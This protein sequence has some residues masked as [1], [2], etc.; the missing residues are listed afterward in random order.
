MASDDGPDLRRVQTKEDFG[1]ELKTLLGRPVRDIEAAAAELVEKERLVLRGR[2]GSGFRHRFEP[3]SKSA[4]SDYRRGSRVPSER[5]LRTLLAIADVRSEE[6]K[7]AW[8]AVRRRVLTEPR[9]L[10]GRR[11]ED[12]DPRLLGVHRAISADGAT[13]FLPPYIVR[14]IDTEQDGLR[15]KVRAAAEGSGFILLVGGSSV[16]KTRS[17]YEAAKELLSGWWL[18]QPADPAD[19][20]EIRELVEAPIPR[21]VVWLDELQRYFGPRGLTA[22]HVRALLTGLGPI[23]LIGTIWPHRY[24]AYIKI[25]HANEPDPYEQERELLALADV[26]T[27]DTAFS[28]AEHDRARNAASMDD[29]IKLGLSSANTASRKLL[30]RHRNSSRNGVPLN[31]TPTGAR[32]S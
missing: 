23:V 13:G 6:A 30:P 7:A 16:G 29:R 11:V 32:F 27:L 25:P 5:A 9:P 20:V 17:A 28:A 15:A 12:A 22:G 26:V 21:T 19:P 2:A 3:L 24:S 1:H 31:S 10:G 18:A 14:D 4:V 8:F